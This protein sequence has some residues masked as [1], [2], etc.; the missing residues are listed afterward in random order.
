MRDSNFSYRFLIIY[1]SLKA[2]DML[3]IHF[4]P[5]VLNSVIYIYLGN[6]LT[7]S[8]VADTTMSDLHGSLKTSIFFQFA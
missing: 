1:F 3:C 7:V 2:T 5:E 6:Y 8:S 4:L